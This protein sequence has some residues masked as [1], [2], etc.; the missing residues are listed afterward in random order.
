MTGRREAERIGLP[1][2]LQSGACR[3]EA[4]QRAAAPA[5]T[6]IADVY[7]ETLAELGLLEG[8]PDCAD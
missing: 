1:I 7:R 2:P 4:P 3:G 6:A 5:P 8:A